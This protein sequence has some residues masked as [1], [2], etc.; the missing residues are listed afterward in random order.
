MLEEVI[1]KSVLSLIILIVPLHLMEAILRYFINKGEK[2]KGVDAFYV[3][4]AKE[5]EKP[6]EKRNLPIFVGSVEDRNQYII[7]VRGKGLWGPIWGYIA[8]KEDYNTV[9]GANFSHDSETPGLGAEIATRQFQKQFIGKKIFA[10]K[11]ITRTD[12]ES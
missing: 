1:I 8:L 4:L 9:Y 11:K 7:P 12:N 2:K 6:V 3:Q 10:L 5:L